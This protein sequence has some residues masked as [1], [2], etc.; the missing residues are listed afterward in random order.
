[1]SD[2]KRKGGDN[3]NASRKKKYRSDGT[4]MWGKRHIDGPGIWVS[5]VK[6]KEKQTV[7]EMYDLFE[8]VASDIWP[9]GGA[10][11]KEKTGDSDDEEELSIEDQIKKEM[12]E[13]KRP[14]AEQRFANCQTDTPCVVFISCKPPVDPVELVVKYIESVAKTGATRSRYTHRLVPVSGTCSANLN[15]MKSLCEK[16]FGAFFEKEK[17][18]TFK[19]KVE[20]RIR[21]HTVLARPAIIQHIASWVPEGHTVSLDNPDIFILVEVF[22]SVCG[23]SIVHDYYKYAKFNVLELSNKVNA[24]KIASEP[25][26]IKMGPS[27]VQGPAQQE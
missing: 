24:Q 19:Y 2:L 4:P 12:S 15:E 6:G 1:M 23:V 27:P 14:R 7:G 25:D 16:V 22:K 21:N 3:H 5:C 26:S 10:E 18:K 9:V 13:M 20:L 8:S 17:G 11:E